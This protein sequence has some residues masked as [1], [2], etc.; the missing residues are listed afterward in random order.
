MGKQIHYTY[1]ADTKLLRCAYDGDRIV[2]T[3]DANITAGL[4][5][6]LEAATNLEIA[7]EH[8]PSGQKHVTLKYKWIYPKV[9]ENAVL[10]VKGVGEFP[11]RKTQSVSKMTISTEKK[12]V[13]FS[14]D[15]VTTDDCNIHQDSDLYLEIEYSKIRLIVAKYLAEAVQSELA[16]G[17]EIH[18]I[19]SLLD[20][21]TVLAACTGK[22]M[23]HWISA[24][25]VG[26]AQS[27]LSE[28]ERDQRLYLIEKETEKLLATLPIASAI[29]TNDKIDILSMAERISVANIANKRRGNG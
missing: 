16:G 3:G 25:S 9:A 27:L 13:S 20:N 15:S 8:K 18:I 7:I 21:S 5:M 10:V 17:K 22:R 24:Y 2:Y 26:P 28:R 23:E 14:V 19:I 1:L 6:L 29:V 12:D 11:P 4:V